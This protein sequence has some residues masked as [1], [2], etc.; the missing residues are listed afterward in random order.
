MRST[1]DEMAER[2]YDGQH[3]AYA[4]AVRDVAALLDPQHIPLEPV[5]QPPGSYFDPRTG[6]IGEPSPEGGPIP[7]DA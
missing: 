3:D 4:C 5:S 6:S 1:G 2:Y 7:E